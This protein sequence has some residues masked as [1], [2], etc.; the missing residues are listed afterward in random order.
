MER[1]ID[2]APVLAG[3]LFGPL[4]ERTLFEQVRLDTEAHTL[5][6]SERR[7][8]RSRDPI[9]LAP[10]RRR[11]CRAGQAMATRTNMTP[12]NK[13]L[14]PPLFCAVAA[15]GCHLGEVEWIHAKYPGGIEFIGV[16][17]AEKSPAIF[18]SVRVQGDDG[19]VISADCP[20]TFHWHGRDFPVSNITAA[21][22][23]AAGIEPQPVDYKGPEWQSAFVGGA[24]SQNRDYGVEFHLRKDRCVEFYARHDWRSSVSCPFELS[25]PV[26]GRFRFPL[27]EAELK[28]VLGEPKA[29]TTIRGH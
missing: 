21:K 6:W 28:K 23:V 13:I 1:T 10:V 14:L 18:F 16:R 11:V 7:R 17:E 29:I 2:F 8:F 3:E 19:Q 9:R 20:L 5:A 24:D 26:S 12:M 15:A 25:T 27:S 22:L 4:H